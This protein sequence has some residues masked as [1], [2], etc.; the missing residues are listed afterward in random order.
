[1]T[2]AQIKNQ[3]KFSQAIIS[4]EAEQ[5]ATWSYMIQGEDL[6]RITFVKDDGNG[7]SIPA[8]KPSD[9]PSDE[10]INARLVAMHNLA[11]AG[12]S[13]LEITTNTSW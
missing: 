7:Y 2:P 6:S 13:L 12:K 5:K 10:Q 11:D 3:I 8:D 9:F 4:L 1:M